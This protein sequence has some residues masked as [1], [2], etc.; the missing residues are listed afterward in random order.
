MNVIYFPQDGEQN[1]KDTQD[2]LLSHDFVS[3]INLNQNA[4]SKFMNDL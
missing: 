2:S 3:Q 1:D 4:T